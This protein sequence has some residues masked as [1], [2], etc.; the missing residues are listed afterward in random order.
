MFGSHAAKGMSNLA[1][2]TTAKEMGRQRGVS[3]E[4]SRGARV[5][6]Y[7]PG[8]FLLMHS[9]RFAAFGLITL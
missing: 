9:I 7:Y 5:R 6:Y 4:L 8:P 3:G 2:T 1:Y